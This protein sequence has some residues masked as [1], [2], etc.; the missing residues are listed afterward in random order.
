[1]MFF[2]ALHCPLM[3]NFLNHYSNYSGLL[4]KLQTRMGVIF[5]ALISFR[6]TYTFFLM[7]FLME[8]YRPRSFGPPPRSSPVVVVYLLY[9]YSL[10]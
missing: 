2:T 1:M 7:W 8:N 9:F 6:P 3:E 10:H 4:I 5:S